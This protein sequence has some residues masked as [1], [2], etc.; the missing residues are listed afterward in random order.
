[1]FD[2][3]GIVASAVLGGFLSIVVYAVIES[4]R[5]ANKKAGSSK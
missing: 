5:D 4:F 2:A 1:M 3:I